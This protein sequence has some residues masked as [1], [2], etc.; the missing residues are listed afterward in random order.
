MSGL[1]Q[2]PGREE[3]VNEAIAAYLQAVEQGEAADADEWLRRYPELA[4]ELASFF[5]DRAQVERALAPLLG[6]SMNAADVL[7]V[8]EAG[9]RTV[10]PCP[11]RTLGQ[12]EVHGELGKG[13]MGVVYRARQ[14]KLN[15][16]VALKTIRAGERAGLPELARFQAEAEAVARLDHPNI[17]PIYEVG[18]QEGQPW[19]SMKLFPGGNL[20]ERLQAGP[21]PP[22]QAA[23]LLATVARAV[24][25]AHQRGV[26]HRDLKPANV[27]LDEQGKPHVTDFGLARRL[28]EAPAGAPRTDSHAIVGTAGYMAPEQASGRTRQLTT[29][30]DVHALGAIL[31]ECLTGKPPFQGANLLDT[32]R[33]LRDEVP[34][35][36][37]S[38]SPWPGRCVRPGATTSS[39]WCA[40]P[41]CAAW[42]AGSIPR[43]SPLGRSARW[44]GGSLRLVC[45]CASTAPWSWPPRPPSAP[46]S[47]PGAAL[48]PSNK[49]SKGEKR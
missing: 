45:S 25:H 26:L 44:S 16:V 14:A 29:A 31:Y 33:R 43:P 7:T 4:D 22:R 20:A 30:A 19:Y 27:L 8:A 47:Q 3:Q 48:P 23:K 24:H 42:G 9:T 13:G 40:R 2:P 34:A 18:E 41:G 17:V 46:R 49:G 15:R 11:V 21:L 6:D 35:R 10:Q 39:A 38:A 36:P 28:V 37:L 12:Y 32:L 5:A 1:T